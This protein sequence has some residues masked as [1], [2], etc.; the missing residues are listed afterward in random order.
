MNKYDNYVK[1]MISKIIIK[2]VKDVHKLNI[3]VEKTN[4]INNLIVKEYINEFLGNE[5]N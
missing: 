5:Y 1:K 3:N 2:Q 4:L